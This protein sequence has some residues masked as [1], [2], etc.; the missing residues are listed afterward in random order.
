MEWS[1]PDAT[2]YSVRNYCTLGGQSGL[3]EGLC[4]GTCGLVSGGDVNWT[5]DGVRST[6][7]S[8][9][10]STV[11]SMEYGVRSIVFPEISSISPR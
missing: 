7:S 8:S 6:V 4:A 10:W 1:G 5:E 2:P 11:W 9:W 3:E